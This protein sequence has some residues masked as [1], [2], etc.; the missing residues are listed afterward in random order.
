[1]TAVAQRLFEVAEHPV[2]IL[3]AVQDRIHDANR[4][5]CRFL[6]YTHEQLLATPISAIH[7]AELERLAAWTRSG[8]ESGHAW[9]TTF[10]CRH[11]SGTI[12]PTEI[13]LLAPDDSDYLF[14]FVRDRS[15]HRAP[16]PP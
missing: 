14:C 9:S 3:D 10:S 6:G 16:A 2:F 1:M 12:M 4:A 15:D 8:R 13:E 5:A 11:R 7:P